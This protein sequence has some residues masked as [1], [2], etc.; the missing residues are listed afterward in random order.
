MKRSNPPGGYQTT[1]LYLKLIKDGSQNSSSKTWHLG[2]K[3]IYPLG[4]YDIDP[5][6]LTVDIVHTASNSGTDIIS[7]QGRSFLNIF[8][9]DSK[10]ESG[11]EVEGGDGKIDIDNPWILNLQEGEIWFPF[12]MPFAYDENSPFAIIS[13]GSERYW[14]NPH[15]D[16]EDIFQAELSD[17]QTMIEDVS[18][19]FI[20]QDGGENPI[21]YWNYTDGP[22]MYY[23]NLASSATNGETRFSI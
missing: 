6:S 19:Y 21:E 4:G 5:S 10:N 11:I 13:N 18:S 8:G 1:V 2:L 17:Q 22:A 15:S 20:L 14:G 12:H 7:S 23:D 9:L 16:L 3:N